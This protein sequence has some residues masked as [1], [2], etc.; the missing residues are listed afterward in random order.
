MKGKQREA[1]GSAAAGQWWCRVILRGLALSF[2]LVGTIFVFFP[3]ATVHA[4]NAIGFWF[5]DFTPLP[6]SHGRFWLSLAT[7]YMALVALLAYAAQRDLRRHRDLLG[8]LALGKATTAFTTLSFYL[9]STPAFIYI[10]NTAVDGAIAVTALAIWLLIPW[11]V[12]PSAVRAAEVAAK[13][14]L[15]SLPVFSAVLE[16]MVPEGG[17]FHE[18]ALSARIEPL[19]EQ[20]V[21]GAAAPMPA[22][23]ALVLRL[24]DLSPFFLPPFRFQRF[25]RLPLSQRVLLLEAWEKSAFP[26]RRQAIHL[27]KLLV[28]AHFYS[29]PEV[30]ARLGYPHPL[31]RVPR[32]Q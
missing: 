1:L 17:P 29:R 6:S 30:E 15:L 18:G 23:L 24:I 9:H 28:V 27:L 10:A 22:A 16:A 5:G 25:S 20:F 26:P 21:A 7:G 14:P 8:F 12:P 11:I 13:R 3:D 4:M 32:P 31:E 2:F 19:I